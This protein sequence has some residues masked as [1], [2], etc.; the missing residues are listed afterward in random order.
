MC[1][2][3]AYVVLSVRCEDNGTQLSSGISQEPRTKTHAAQWLESVEVLGTAWGAQTS[4]TA[5]KQRSDA[6]DYEAES[7]HTYVVCN[8]LSKQM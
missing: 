8:V 5:I 3:Y 2:T 1:R 6:I 7:L 4:Q